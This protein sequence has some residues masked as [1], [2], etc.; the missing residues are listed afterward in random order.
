[1]NKQIKIIIKLEYQN[2]HC[3][4]PDKVVCIVKN[5]QLTIIVFLH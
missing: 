4:P 3:S 1:M 2:P 5:K